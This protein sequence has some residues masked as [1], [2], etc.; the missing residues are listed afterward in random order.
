M[1]EQLQNI[2]IE[3]FNPDF[4]AYEFVEKDVLNLVI[5]SNCFINQS[6]PERIRSVYDRIEKRL[7]SILEEYTIYVNAFTKEEILD[8]RDYYNNEG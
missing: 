8:L 6:M 7:P 4:L 3:D 1:N 2:L 5:S